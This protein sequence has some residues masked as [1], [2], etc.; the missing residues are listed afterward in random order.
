M[1][2]L[3]VHILTNQEAPST[4]PMHFFEFFENFRM[5]SI[6][7]RKWSLIAYAAQIFVT[8]L[9]HP[10]AIRLKMSRHMLK[11]RQKMTNPIF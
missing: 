4:P 2:I 6:L 7:S 5:N 9:G 3:E 1:L 11:N 8:F 10:I